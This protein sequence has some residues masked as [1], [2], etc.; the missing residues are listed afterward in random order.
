MIGKIKEWLGDEEYVYD[1]EIE[2]VKLS[3]GSG[4]L[5]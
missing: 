1:Y 5:K 3:C 2:G 4:G